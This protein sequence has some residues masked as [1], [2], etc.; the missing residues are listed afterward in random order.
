MALGSVEA[1]LEA[2]CPL[3]YASP[4]RPIY[5]DIATDA[6]DAS[7]FGNQYF[8]AIALGAA[9]YFTIDS[10]RPDGEAGLVTS[11]TEGRVSIHYWNEIPEGSASSLH[12]TTYGKR[13]LELM[14]RMRPAVSVCGATLP[15]AGMVAEER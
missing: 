15:G 3:L 9:H 13:L 2:L 10:N 8:Y 6:T 11:K 14:R 1:Y 12:M 4:L 7:Y 5:V